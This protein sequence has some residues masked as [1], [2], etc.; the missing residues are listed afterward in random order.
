MKLL[1]ICGVPGTGKTTLGKYF[2][3]K[4]YLHFDRELIQ[5]WPKDLIQLWIN[6][7]ED[8]AKAI[9]G[10]NK[11][12]VLTWGFM[13]GTDDEAIKT[14]QRLGFKLIWLD[15]NREAA[16]KAFIQRGTVPV[17]L[18]DIQMARIDAMNIE[19]FYPHVIINPF[20]DNGMF[21]TK[22]VIAEKIIEAR[23]S[24]ELE[25]SG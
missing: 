5:G 19:D 14:L 18:L 22:E 6:S 25:P 15:G 10:F 3:Q 13:P 4:G 16:R 8:F 7:L 12:I 21:L 9:K 2:E 1:L 20:D 17:E 24:T 23:H 11:N